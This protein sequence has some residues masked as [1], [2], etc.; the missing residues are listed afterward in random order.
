MITMFDMSADGDGA[1]FEVSVAR[2]AVPEFDPI[3]VAY[4]QQT[5]LRLLTLDEA[6]AAERRQ[7]QVPDIR[8]VYLHAG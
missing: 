2:N 1:E 5:S 7:L 3:A 4:W 6:V 8:S